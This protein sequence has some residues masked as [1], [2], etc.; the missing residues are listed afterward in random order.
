M[1]TQKYEGYYLDEIIYKESD[2]DDEAELDDI[3]EM[4]YKP[5]ENKK[6]KKEKLK[7]NI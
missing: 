4:V 1:S 2:K 7:K 3:Y 5:N 6:E